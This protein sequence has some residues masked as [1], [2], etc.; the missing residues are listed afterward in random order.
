MAIRTAGQVRM[1]GER[2][3][4]GGSV[5]GRTVRREHELDRQLEQRTQRHKD[6]LG[7]HALCSPSR[8]G[9]SR[10]SGASRT[11]A[12]CSCLSRRCH[13]RFN[14][15]SRTRPDAWKRSSPPEHERASPSSGIRRARF[16]A[17]SPPRRVR[18][19][20]AEPDGLM[21]PGSSTL[22]DRLIYSLGTFPSRRADNVQFKR[23]NARLRTR[24]GAA[25]SSGPN[26]GPDAR[27]P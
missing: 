3:L 27:A 23:L 14:A 17:R 25:C 10:T 22:V 24:R 12:S 6:L 4:E 18:L 8:P 19:A 1:S 5:G 21:P 13:V 11:G 26:S 7:R 15:S 9:S 16:R 2:A 20:R